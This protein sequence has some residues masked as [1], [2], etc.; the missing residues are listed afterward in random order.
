MKPETEGFMIYGD[1]SAKGVTNGGAGN[2]LSFYDGSDPYAGEFAIS[3]SSPAQYQSV[4]F[5]LS[6]NKDLSLLEDG[7]HWI[8]LW[9]KGDS[10]DSNF[11]L[12]FHDTKAGE[13]DH[14]WRM[15][16]H[17]DNSDV[18]FDGEWNLLE[19]PLSDFNEQGSWDDNQWHNPEG[20]FDWTAIDNF[21]IVS[22]SGAQNGVSFWFD[23][24]KIDGP[25][26]NSTEDFG[27]IPVI[28]QLNQNY[29]NPFN[30]STIISYQLPMSSNVQLTIFDNLGR[31]ISTLVN[32]EQTSGS[33]NVKFDGSALASG[34]YFY[35]LRAGDYIQRKSMMLIK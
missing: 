31:K 26:I 20:K 3:W 8:S 7:E 15:F 10:P 27:I 1:Y 14:P 25:V 5:D 35:E 17:V 21:Q 23:E 24:I 4:L 13:D 18:A 12:R 29:P 22:E 6:P 11:D 9:V 28:F 32:A 2:P 19:I 30:P 33:Y 34:I 16:Y